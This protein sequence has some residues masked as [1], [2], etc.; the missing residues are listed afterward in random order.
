MCQGKLDS[1]EIVAVSE[2]STMKADAMTKALDELDSL[3][4]KTAP[5]HGWWMAGGWEKND[6]GP[7]KKMETHGNPPKNIEHF[8]EKMF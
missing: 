1:G 3:R 8:L 7:I 5:G 4:D 6:R 2:G